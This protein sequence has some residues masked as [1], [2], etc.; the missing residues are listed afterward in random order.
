MFSIE[1]RP[2]IWLSMNVL[3]VLRLRVRE[4]G[5]RLVERRQVRVGLAALHLHE[6]VEVL[7]WVVWASQAAAEIV[8]TPNGVP[9]GGGSKMPF[10][11]EPLA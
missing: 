10:D 2:E 5:E 6:R 11:P 3:P 9:P 1:L 4:V 7:G 8:T